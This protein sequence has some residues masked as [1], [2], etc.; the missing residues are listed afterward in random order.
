M[1]QVMARSG[2]RWRVL[3]VLAI[4]IAFVLIEALGL[5]NTYGQLGLV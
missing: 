3:V 2:N 4:I 5:C 1:P